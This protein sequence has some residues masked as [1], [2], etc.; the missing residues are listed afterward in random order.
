MTEPLVAAVE[1]GG[2][3]I[4]CA[5]GRSW[6]EVLSAEKHTVATGEPDETIRQVTSWF[7]GLSAAAEIAAV[8]VA[9]FGPLDLCRG[10]VGPTP[11]PGWSGFD[12]RAAIARWRPEAAFGFETDT[13]GAAMAEG[14]WGAGVGR[15][16]CAYVTVGTGIGGGAIIGGE[17]VH[18]LVHPEIG[19]TRI[20]RQPGD[21]FAGVCPF[22]GDCLEG[23]AS[24]PAIEVRWGRPGRDLEHDH[25]AWELEGRYLAVAVT[26]LAMTLSPEVIVMGGGVMEAPGLLDKV[27]R[28][29]RDL[30]AGY[31]D[32][33]LLGPR[34]DRYIVAPGLGSASGVLGAFAAGR[35]ALGRL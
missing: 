25:P 29:T 2:T 28:G 35:R 17:P 14:A 27:C 24:G 26:N 1:A 15:Q 3:K 13:N 30:V 10:R 33:D 18:G 4:I 20:P 9:A 31:V 16:V 12:W 23:M 6:E 7:D 32:S 22:H 5:M 34:I 8:G 11:K 21:D 19:H